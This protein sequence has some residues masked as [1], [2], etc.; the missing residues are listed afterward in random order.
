MAQRGKLAPYIYTPEK[1]GLNGVTLAATRTSN[2]FDMRYRSALTV[3]VKA[4]RAAY[5]ALVLTFQH[6]PDGGTTWADVQSESIAAGA[7][8]L[9][10]YSQTKTTSSSVNYSTSLI[11]LSYKDMRVKIAGTAGGASDTVQVWVEVK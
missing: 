2:S 8:T 5:T 9:T 11:D 1:L 4:T 6:S 3:T 10:D 7:G